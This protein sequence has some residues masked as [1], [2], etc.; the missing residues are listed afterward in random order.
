MPDI[1]KLPTIPWKEGV[2]FHQGS[3]NSDTSSDQLI[4]YQTISTRTYDYVSDSQDYIDKLVLNV[5]ESC[6]DEY[7]EDGIDSSFAKQLT[8]L[9]FWYE[10]KALL[11]ISNLVHNNK[12][13]PEISAETLCLLGRLDHLPT[14][15][16]RLW[17]L[18]RSLFA[19]HPLVRDG[20]GIGIAS[21]DDP[22]AIPYLEKAIG[23]EALIG[24]RKDLTDVLAQLNDTKKCLAY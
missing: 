16:F 4:S 9:V 22:K 10:N 7:F 6:K 2:V 18:E 3:H 8:S 14:H 1:S 17:I 19:V 15:E 11:T 20:A 12:V 23:K 21:F 24:I 13:K 5:F